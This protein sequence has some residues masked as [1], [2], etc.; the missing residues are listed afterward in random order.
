[1]AWASSLLA[2][3]LRAGS[4]APRPRDPGTLADMIPALAAN[5]LPAVARLAEETAWLNEKA[6]VP[7]V[8]GVRS[9]RQAEVGRVSEHVELSPAEILQRLAGASR[10]V[11]CGRCA[12]FTSRGQFCRRRLRY[13]ET[14]RL[15]RHRLQNPCWTPSGRSFRDRGPRV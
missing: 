7:F 12:R 1:M 9:E 15:C 4:A 2:I 8:E 10:S 3:E 13:R 6:L 11:T 14:G 5:G